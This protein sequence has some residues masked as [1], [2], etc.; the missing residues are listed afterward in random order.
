MIRKAFASVQLI[1]QLFLIATPAFAQAGWTPLASYKEKRD[2]RYITT[3]LARLIG[4]EWDS[5]IGTNGSRVVRFQLM[6][7][8]KSVGAMEMIAN[9]SNEYVRFERVIPEPDTGTEYFDE[10]AMPYLQQS[11]PL[12]VKKFCHQ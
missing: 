5:G 4:A 6:L 8:G 2:Q 1:V 3:I 11:K 9:C 12:A 10:S 7:K